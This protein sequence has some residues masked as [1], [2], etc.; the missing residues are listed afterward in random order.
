MGQ[1]VWHR[2]DI[3]NILRGVEL[4]CRESTARQVSA[5]SEA[6]RAGYVAALAAAATSFGIRV[7]PGEGAQPSANGSAWLLAAG[8]RYNGH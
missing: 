1:T 4:A 7:R 3:E 8:N 6:F 2:E 5:E